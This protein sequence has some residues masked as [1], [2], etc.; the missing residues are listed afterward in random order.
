VNLKVTNASAGFIFEN[1]NNQ[2]RA[3]KF[4]MVNDRI[5]SLHYLLSKSDK[6]MASLELNL[7][8]EPFQGIQLRL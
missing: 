2:A 1:N 4:V 8:V 7:E 6:S 3:F 5:Y